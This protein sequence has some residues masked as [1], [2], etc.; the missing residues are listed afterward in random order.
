MS[1]NVIEFL[2]GDTR[3][4]LTLSQ[5]RFISQV[6]KL[7]EQYPEEC[8]ILAQNEDGSICAYVPVT[9]IQ[10]RKPKELTEEQRAR[11]TDNLRTSQT[12]G[13]PGKNQ[14]EFRF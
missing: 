13:K 4:T 14:T 10:I 9:W 2:R 3:A 1:E 7:A 6:R 8:G 11:A 5:G 12:S